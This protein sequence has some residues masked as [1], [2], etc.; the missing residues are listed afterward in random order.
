MSVSCLASIS[1]GQAT[2]LVVGDLWPTKNM[3]V[4]KQQQKS[5]PAAF[6]SALSSAAIQKTKD[7]LSN[8]MMYSEDW[9]QTLSLK[10]CA[11]SDHVQSK[12]S[13]GSDS[14]SERLLPS[15]VLHSYSS[16]LSQRLPSLISSLC[17][18]F[19]RRL[20]P[21]KDMH[22]LRQ[23]LAISIAYWAPWENSE[24]TAEEE[25]KRQAVFLRECP[26]LSWSQL[27]E[28]TSNLVC[29]LESTAAIVPKGLSQA[30]LSGK[31]RV[32]ELVGKCKVFCE[33]YLNGKGVSQDLSEGYAQT[34]FQAMNNGGQEA[35]EQWLSWGPSL[36]GLCRDLVILRSLA[37]DLYSPTGLLH[38]SSE[39]SS[40]TAFVFLD[41]NA[42]LALISA[43]SYSG[44]TVEEII[45]SQAY[46]NPSDKQSPV[47]GI[48]KK[49][50]SGFLDV[51]LSRALTAG[52][53]IK[54]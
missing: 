10:P 41:H 15:Q 1:S 38:A 44:F 40:V 49:M 43:L 23:F 52:D 29:D 5:I 2:I 7:G 31:E 34:Y 27:L 39:V 47:D 16:S 50:I 42:A 33:T 4:H 30:L 32:V 12:L 18:A 13:E 26:D 24:P 45:G 25:E 8:Y 53:R 36:G 46:F 9:G 11:A 20:I 17:P 54:G 19:T 28:Y 22:L 48:S 35:L 21:S 6:Q 37:T 3:T 14:S 51:S